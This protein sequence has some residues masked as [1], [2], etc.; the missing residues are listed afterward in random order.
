MDNFVLELITTF[1]ALIGAGIG[2]FIPS[3]IN[4]MN[5]K[6][7]HMLEQHEQLAVEYIHSHNVFVEA[8]NDFMCRC[9]CVNKPLSM[10]LEEYDSLKLNLF[11][12]ASNAYMVSGPC[13]R[14]LIGEIL[15][16]IDDRRSPPGILG[17]PEPS[18]LFWVYLSEVSEENI[19]LRPKHLRGIRFKRKHRASSKRIKAVPKE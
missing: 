8:F 3:W 6:H 4:F 19:S 13:V 10:T 1:G 18:I 11:K 5:Q 12:A 16:S 7:M 15:A 14:Q 2:A 17:S 9:P